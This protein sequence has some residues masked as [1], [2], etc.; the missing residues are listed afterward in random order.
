MRRYESWAHKISSWKYLTIW[1]PVLP[2]SAPP[3]PQHRGP[4]FCSPPWA[5]FRGWWKSAAAAA[6]D[7]ILVEV[8]G[9]CQFAADTT[10]QDEYGSSPE[11]GAQEKE[12][13]FSVHL[14]RGPNDRVCLYTDPRYVSFAKRKYTVL[15]CVK[16]QDRQHIHS[17]WDLTEE[18]GFAQSKQWQGSGQPKVLL[19]FKESEVRRAETCGQFHSAR[20]KWDIY[21]YV[22]TYKYLYCVFCKRLSHDPFSQVEWVRIKMWFTECLL[23]L[24]PLWKILLLS[25]AISIMSC[26]FWHVNET[27]RPF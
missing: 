20:K 13:G 11:K 12:R 10:H 14:L 1:G 3:P 4:H 15:V 19:C 17:P 25:Q 2:V 22:H 26:I 18:H 5:P 16:H 8:D 6:R 24:G 21:I 7:L 27:W 23:Y 9:K